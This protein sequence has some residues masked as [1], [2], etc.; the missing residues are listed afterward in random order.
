LSLVRRLAS[1]GEKSNFHYFVRGENRLMDLVET[2]SRRRKATDKIEQP[3]EKKEKLEPKI[4]RGL[5]GTTIDL[6]K[7]KLSDLKLDIKTPTLLLNLHED[8]L[9]RVEKEERINN[10]LIKK[11]NIN[12]LGTDITVYLVRGQNT[13]V[14][15]P[16]HRG[17]LLC[18]TTVILL[19]KKS[20]G[21][22]LMLFKPKDSLRLQ[23]ITEWKPDKPY[24][25]AYDNPALDMVRSLGF[26]NV[27]PTEIGS[28]SAPRKFAGYPWQSFSE[29]F[30]AKVN[31]DI[32]LDS[33]ISAVQKAKV[34]TTIPG[35][36]ESVYWIH[37]DVWLPMKDEI[38][39]DTD[40]A[41]MVLCGH[42]LLSARQLWLRLQNQ[43][44]S[45]LC[46]NPM[47][48]YDINIT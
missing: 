41:A 10:L 48:H 45:L 11:A 27:Y 33:K 17:D 37:Q 16:G 15:F 38:E 4:Y 35:E 19:T 43:E 6:N 22:W 30:Y 7:I 39:V 14:S 29:V 3:S 1:R 34:T 8:D 31:T 26:I 5:D 46:T 42:H 24:R 13:L 40:G 23:H 9:E 20:D 18:Y 28:W 36:Y 47:R 44:Y 21:Y 32:K 12:P 2:P 25:Y